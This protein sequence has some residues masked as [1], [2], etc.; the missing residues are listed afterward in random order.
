[1]THI[2]SRTRVR[3]FL[4]QNISIC[5][6]LSFSSRFLSTTCI[7]HDKKTGISDSNKIEE[8]ASEEAIEALNGFKARYADFLKGQD[9]KHKPLSSRT[10]EVDHDQLHLLR[11]TK[12]SMLPLGLGG[13]NDKSGKIG[14]EYEAHLC[15]NEEDVLLSE[16]EISDKVW[17]HRI[18]GS[19]KLIPGEHLAL[20]LPRV[21]SSS[22]GPD[23]S[24]TTFNPPGGVFTRRM[25][26]GGHMEWTQNKKNR[27]IKTLLVNDR[28]DEKTYVEGAELK[29]SSKGDEMILVRIRKEFE[30]N[31]APVLIDKRS[32]I[33]QRALSPS[34]AQ[35]RVTAAVNPAPDFA[36][37][38]PPDGLLYPTLQYQTPANLFRYSAL[39]FNAHAIHLS[40]PW[41]QQVEGHQG[42]LVHGPLNLSLLIRK[43]GRDIAG[44]HLIE[45][46]KLFDRRPGQKKQ[47][48]KSVQ[49]RAKSPVCAEQPYWIGIQESTSQTEQQSEGEQEHTV[50]AI[51][52]DGKIIMEAKI[53]S[54]SEN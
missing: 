34:N 50:V 13:E 41:A 18:D 49:Y 31:D 5:P 52:P 27:R 44:W 11:L 3:L 53:K 4:H 37:L 19:S 46:G 25:W 30:T 48:I 35:P 28:I 1:M 2:L 42:I 8:W 23:G 21:P 39:T 38:S 51:K 12:A 9:G 7:V 43:W 17:K 29:K 6:A 16:R 47:S 24:D 14:L 33:Y 36:S 45:N 32:W 20:L 54:I 15:K 26:A 22:L 40:P 10:R